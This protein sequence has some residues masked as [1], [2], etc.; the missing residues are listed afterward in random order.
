MTQAEA[1]VGDGDPRRITLT[2]TTK[3]PEEL[4]AG[5]PPCASHKEKLRQ[6]PVRVF[7]KLARQRPTL[8]QGCPCST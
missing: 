1:S 5:Q 2:V 4:Q 7:Q 8:P 6:F 3:R